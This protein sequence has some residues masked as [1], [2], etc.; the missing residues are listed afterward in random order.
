MRIN[1]AMIGAS[2]AWMAFSRS[3]VFN[4]TPK[5]DPRRAQYTTGTQ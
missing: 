5:P 4:A 2:A 1:S 3:L